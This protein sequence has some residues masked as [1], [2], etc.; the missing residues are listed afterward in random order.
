MSKAAQALHLS[1]ASFATMATF[2]IGPDPATSDYRNVRDG[3]N[4]LTSGTSEMPNI[5]EIQAGS[6]DITAYDGALP[7]NSN[8]GYCGFFNPGLSRFFSS[9]SGNSPIEH[10]K[11]LGAFDPDTGVILT[12]ITKLTRIYAQAK[13]AGYS[14]PS[15]YT[16]ADVNLDFDFQSGDEYILQ[17]GNYGSTTNSVKALVLED[18]KFTGTHVGSGSSNRGAYSLLV[19]ADGLYY[20]RV[21]VASTFGGQ[22]TYIAGDEDTISIGGSAF[23]FAQGNNMNVVDSYFNES[24]YGNAI[25]LYDSTAVNLSGNVFEAGGQLKELGQTF[26]NTT[27]QI[28]NNA[29]YGGS[30]LTVAKPTASDL[31][32]TGNDFYAS[33][34]DGTKT[35]VGVEGIV[36]EGNTQTG[37]AQF[38]SFK[39]SGNTFTDVVPIVTNIT[40]GGTGYTSTA[41][42]SIWNP[43]LGIAN[44]FQNFN[45]VVGGS[46]NDT[47][48]G[49][50]SSDFLLGAQGQ[51]RLTGGFGGDAFAFTTTPDADV[52]TDWKQGTSSTGDRIWLDDAIFKN[53]SKGGFTGGNNSGKFYSGTT[54]GT[55][56]IINYKSDSRQLYYDPSNSGK[57]DQLICT[58]S[59]STIVAADLVVF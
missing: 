53:L 46:G 59:H 57:F 19:A 51:D 25:T 52:I 28:N 22:K 7:Q 21:N 8:V 48:S 47:L 10:I 43:A 27:G 14:I 33:T 31:T 30:H 39:I 26:S 56:G 4:K 2:T 36:L 3:I 54:P 45:I 58:T 11:L 41:G 6:Y 32:V 1:P 13:D 15:N 23:L 5:V 18:V 35:V 16:I 55:A 50:T 20:S 42:N 34:E 17:G 24:G 37:F 40:T 12:T 49:G 9:G 38:N 44:K 29:F